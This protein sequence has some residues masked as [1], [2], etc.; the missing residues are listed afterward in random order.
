MNDNISTSGK[1]TA[2]DLELSDVFTGHVLIAEGVVNV[3]YKA[4]R[5]GQ[6]FVLKALRPEF[7][8]DLVRRELLTREFQL[9]KRMDHPNIVRLF[10]LAQTAINVQ[11][12][13]TT[14]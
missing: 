10:S 2:D 9:G 12:P 13:L 3:P 7:R 6:W 4:R 11:H 1:V 8:D 14:C 5:K